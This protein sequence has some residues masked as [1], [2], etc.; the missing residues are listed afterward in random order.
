MVMEVQVAVGARGPM[1]AAIGEGRLVDATHR[2]QSGQYC[3]RFDGADEGESLSQTCDVATTRPS[4]SEY[5]R[6][7]WCDA[8][9]SFSFELHRTCSGAGAFATV[10]DTGGQRLIREWRRRDFSPFKDRSSSVS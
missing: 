8:A 5:L 4:I 3:Q 10:F 9:T 1:Q 6:W 7:N 2:G